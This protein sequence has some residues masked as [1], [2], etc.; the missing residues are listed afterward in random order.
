[1]Q[2]VPRSRWHHGEGAEG[3]YNRLGDVDNSQT[4]HRDVGTQS[5]SHRMEALSHNSHTQEDCEEEG[6]KS[7]G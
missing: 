5:D 4:L 2:K 3:S 7:A 6:P 1:M